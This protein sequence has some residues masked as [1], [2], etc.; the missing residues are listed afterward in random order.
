[1]TQCIRNSWWSSTGILSGVPM[2]ILLDGGVN[3]WIAPQTI[4]QC[5]S[6]GHVFDLM[7]QLATE[8]GGP[9]MEAPRGALGPGREG[10]SIAANLVSP[11]AEHCPQ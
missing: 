1:M 7:K 2:G 11:F 4:M 8:V 9:V 3:V 6:H 10:G 5:Y